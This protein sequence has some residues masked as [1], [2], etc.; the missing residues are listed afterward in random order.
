[1]AI[2]TFLAEVSTLLSIFMIKFLAEYL[3]KEESDLSEASILVALFSFFLLLGTLLRN[4]Y[5]Y[6]GYIMSLEVRKVLISAIYDKVSRLTM[7][8]LTATNQ[9]RLITMVSSDIFGLERSLAMAPFGLSAPFINLVSYGLIWYIAGW[10]YT[11]AIFGLWVVIILLQMWT[12]RRQMIMKQT[13]SRRN[14]ERMKLINDMI[15]G[16]STI[17]AYAWEK[18]YQKKVR[19]QRQLQE[20]SV[21]YLN[22][23]GSLGF[24]I[25]QNI[26]LIGILCIFLP[27]WFMSEELVLSDSFTLLAMVYYLFFCVNSLTHQSISTMC[28]ASQVM[29]HVSEL[30]QMEEHEKTHGEQIVD[31]EPVIDIKSGEYSWGFQR[32]KNNDL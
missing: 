22:L 21:F 1:M 27:K 15:T 18:H 13:E 29:S 20:K 5:L 4:F 25:F 23:I 6:Y 31:G 26:G 12:T 24:N 30:L 2:L 14:D 11:I 17:K 3:I 8:S 9:G 32:K 16:I 10:P 28:S 19:D 7:R